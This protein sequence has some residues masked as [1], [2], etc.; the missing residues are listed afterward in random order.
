[1]EEEKKLV[2]NE[3]VDGKLTEF[4]KTLKEV[5]LP[6]KASADFITQSL[7]SPLSDETK[8]K[9]VNEL[10]DDMKKRIDGDV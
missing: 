9:I 6:I 8:E 2:I 3:N 5:I 7:M 1:M 4:E 10:Y